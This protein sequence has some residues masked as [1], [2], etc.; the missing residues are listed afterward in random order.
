MLVTDGYSTLF[1]DCLSGLV[2]KIAFPGLVPDYFAG[3][4]LE[5]FSIGMAQ[6]NKLGRDDRD[7]QK[8]DPSH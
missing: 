8:L 4:C 6:S 7:V 3:R 2:A 5:N 1:A